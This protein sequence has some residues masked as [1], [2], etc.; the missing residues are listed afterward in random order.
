M[1][2]RDLSSYQERLEEN[3][4]RT[5]VGIWT[6]LELQTSWLQGHSAAWSVTWLYTKWKHAGTQTYP[7]LAIFWFD[8]L[9]VSAECGRC[10]V[11][12][13]STGLLDLEMKW[14]G[15]LPCHWFARTAAVFSLQGI[16]Y[17]STCT[18]RLKEDK[19]LEKF[20]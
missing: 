15:H 3:W 18:G 13:H 6:W 16:R 10:G 9:L 14:E 7:V 4:S 20:S 11:P 8:S 12:W 19:N 1:S 17:P 5:V 2:M